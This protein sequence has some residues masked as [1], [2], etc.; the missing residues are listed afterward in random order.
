[1]QEAEYLI[2]FEPFI[3]RQVRDYQSRHAQQNCI[4]LDDLLQEARIVFLNHIRKIPDEST[5]MN[6]K[7]AIHGALCELS[8]SMSLVRIPKYCYGDEIRKIQQVDYE[9]AVLES[10]ERYAY[11][12]ESELILREFENTLTEKERIVCRMKQ[13]G[14]SSREIIPFV[15]VAGEPQMSRL[16]K[17]VRMKA[18]L[19][20]AV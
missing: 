3:Q 10:D 15:G 11:G 4:D 19:Y 13:H 20:F 18:T 17:S 2:R 14:Y 5:I 7:Y 1:M 9:D 16:L 8:R 12:A 6:C